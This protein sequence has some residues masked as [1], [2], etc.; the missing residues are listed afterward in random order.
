MDGTVIHA[1]NGDLDLRLSPASRLRHFCSAVARIVRDLVTHERGTSIAG[2]DH[3]SRAFLKH[4]FAAA[5]FEHATRRGRE[6][7]TSLHPVLVTATI[8]AWAIRQHGQAGVAGSYRIADMYS[9]RD[10]LGPTFK[11]AYE[12]LVVPFFP[13]V[14]LRKDSASTILSLK[15][16]LDGEKSGAIFAEL[17]RQRLY[18]IFG[19]LLP[20][21]F[22]VQLVGRL[23]AKTELI[24]TNPGIID[25]KSSRFGDS[26]IVDF[27][28][29]SQLFPPGQMMIVFNTFRGELRATIIYNARRFSGS[30]VADFAEMIE[31]EMESI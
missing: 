22:A 4:G 21:K 17:Y 3:S 12:T 6:L 18:R 10:L 23:I 24:I 29:F 31:R 2:G 28:S 8:R 19:R 5:T 1:W 30:E 7:G 11:D 9:F 26:D 25:V 20:T 14:V 27:Y 15:R 13:R 16:L